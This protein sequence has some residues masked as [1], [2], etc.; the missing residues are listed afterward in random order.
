MTRHSLRCAALRGATGRSTTS[1]T[2]L[3]VP[4]FGPIPAPREIGNPG[5]VVLI[6]PLFNR[7]TTA[8]VAPVIALLDYDSGNIRS[9]EKALRHSGAEV[10]RT[11]TP[12]AMKDARGI[13]LPGVGAFDDCVHALQR[14]ELDAAVKDWIAQGRPFLGICVGYQALFERSEEFN[15]CARGLGVFE[16]PVVRFQT[17]PTGPRLDHRGLR[18]L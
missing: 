13:V 14:Q 9:V 16:G 1:S 18:G 11:R 6:T 15:S 17:T 8:S 7:R 5:G 10:V 12:A 4:L 2:S 3:P